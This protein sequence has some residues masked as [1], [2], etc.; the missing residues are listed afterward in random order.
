MSSARAPRGRAGTVFIA[1]QED[2]V[3][4]GSQ[5]D[6][7]FTGRFGG[8]LDKGDRVWDS[9]DGLALEE[10]LAWARA[11]ADRIVVRVGHGL[12]YAIGFAP[13]S[14]LPWPADG[15]E[16]PARRRTPDEA[17]KDRTDAD[18][19]A[20]W[21]ATIAL[22]PPAGGA[23]RASPPGVGRDRRVRRRAASSDVDDRQPRRLVRRQARSRAT[24]AS[25]AH[26]RGR[27]GDHAHPRL[28]DRTDRSGP[29]GR[30]GRGR[31]TWQ[32]ARSFRRLVGARRRS[33]HRQLIG[34]R[35]PCV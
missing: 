1:E 10:A 34:A 24:S 4:T 32:P 12:R 20:T 18:P 31:G 5:H 33:V 2:A 35:T 9:F 15:L 29:H 14:A 19:D 26:R 6:H 7:Y 25:L 13:D 30:G 27:M 17:W 28:R 21:Q 11:R 23:G 16:P 22:A 8:Y 3:F